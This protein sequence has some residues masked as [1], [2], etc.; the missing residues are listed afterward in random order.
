MCIGLIEWKVN[1]FIQINMHMRAHKKRRVFSFIEEQKKKEKK[2]IV[3]LKEDD[4]G[5]KKLLC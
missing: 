5:E 2:Y 4:V 3:V 1:D